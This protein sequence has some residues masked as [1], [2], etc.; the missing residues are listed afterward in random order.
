M[1]AMTQVILRHR[2]A[3]AV[4]VFTGIACLGFGVAMTLSPAAMRDMY[5]VVSQLSRVQTGIVALLTVALGGVL[6]AGAAGHPLKNWFM[7]L[8]VL[9]LGKGAA[10]FVPGWVST[11]STWYV[12]QTDPTWRGLGMSL[13]VLG[14]AIIWR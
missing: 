1:I 4:F 6:V 5:E 11:V 3:E 9:S 8:G 14:A 7:V 13:L 10:L 12:R 2:F